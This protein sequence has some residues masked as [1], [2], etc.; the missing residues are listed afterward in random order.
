MKVRG[1][2]VAFVMFALVAQTA[3]AQSPAPSY[4]PL[5]VVQLEDACHTNAVSCFFTSVHE[6]DG[7]PPSPE[8]AAELFATIRQRLSERPE[9]SYIARL[10]ERGVE[11]MAQKV[12]EEATEVV[13]AGV[14]RNR[15]SLIAEMADLWF[16]SYVLLAESGLTPD[17]VWA[18][19]AKRRR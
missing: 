2:A 17:D 10:A 13:I 15:E 7:P 18:E 8:Q 1:V 11:R 6:S 9:G 14:T 12:G 19:L 3:T 4:P 5:D 16:H